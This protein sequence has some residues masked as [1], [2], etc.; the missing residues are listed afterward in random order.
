MTEGA[1][2]RG[3]RPVRPV[4]GWLVIDK[5]SGMT[6]AA[7][8]AQVRRHTQSAKAGHGG[9]LDPLATGVLPVALGEATKTMPYAVDGEKTYQ[10]TV[11]WGEARDTDD[12][13]GEIVG[14]SPVRPTATAIE[15]GLACFTGEIEQVPPTYSAIKIGGRRAYALARAA[16]TVTLAAR[17]VTIERITLVAVPDPDHAVL[18]VVARKGVYM[19]AIA[20]DLARAL[21]T[22]GCVAA[23]RRLAV[24][25]FAVDEAIPLERL[26][27][28]GHSV[29]ALGEVLLPVG[30][31]L[32]G[33]PALLLTAAEARSLQHGRP[34][35]VLPVA[36]RSSLQNVAADAIV[37]ATANGKPVALAQIKGG[38]LRPVRVLNF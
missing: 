23:L 11:R 24:G 7:V 14:E 32:A 15:A 16:E 9:T 10:F 21:G 12:I 4:H 6:S 2:G 18:E 35:A 31:A 1:P 33:I 28:I 38:E 25:P 19:R 13:E 22:C 20:R 37:C 17:R 30:A 36:S 3:K 27:A 5:P 8:V 34:I 29:A 26:A